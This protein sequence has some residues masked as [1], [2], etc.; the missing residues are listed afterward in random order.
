MSTTRKTAYLLYRS[1]QTNKTTLSKT[2]TDQW[3]PVD[4]IDYESTDPGQK[5][6]NLP[7]LRRYLGSFRPSLRYVACMDVQRTSNPSEFGRT[8]VKTRTTE[9]V[10]VTH[11]PRN[12]ILRSSLVPVIIV[13]PLPKL[14]NRP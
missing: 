1:F 7:T 14:P 13:G 5:P 6:T 9:S 12:R 10:P 2:T 4:G 3:E 11:Y 8:Y